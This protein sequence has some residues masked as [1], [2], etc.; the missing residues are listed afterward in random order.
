VHHEKTSNLENSKVLSA[1]KIEHKNLKSSLKPID[2]SQKFSGN[3]NLFQPK[4]ND[5][6]LGLLFVSGL[7]IWGLL[8]SHIFWLDFLIIELRIKLPDWLLNA[9]LILGGLTLIRTILILVKNKLSVSI[10]KE[11][12]LYILLTQII[13]TLFINLKT[14]GH[15]LLWIPSALVYLLVLI[16]IYKS[17]KNFT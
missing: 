13:V 15:Y 7:L 5:S 9:I 1:S 4:K 6:G 10:V 11:V 2:I 8:I 16:L 3:K 17:K 12:P 14:Q